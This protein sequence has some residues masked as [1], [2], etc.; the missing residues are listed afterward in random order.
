[1][2]SAGP[3]P[4][5]YQRLGVTPAA[6]TEEVR[7]AYRALARRLHPDTQVGASAAERTLAERRMREVTE[8]FHVLGD[9]TRRRRYDDERLAATGRRGAPGPAARRVGRTDPEASAP[10]PADDDDLVDVAP[11]LGSLGAA[12]YRHLPWIVLVVVLGGIFVATAYAGHDDPPPATVTRT[13][14]AAGTCLDVH[15]GP[16]TTV[17]AC[18]GPH[19]VEVVA[20]ADVAAD[21][22]AGTEARRLADDGRVDCVTPG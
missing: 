4:T 16:S 5:H 9:P 6:S 17:V 22:P 10:V 14:V 8:A 11:H 7:A 13:T 3:T 12:A 19:D 2:A 21:C 20:R 1:M 15:N 18:D